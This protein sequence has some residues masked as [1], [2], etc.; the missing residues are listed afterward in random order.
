MS[1]RQRERV[2]SSQQEV[3]YGLLSR[4]EG[5][6]GDGVLGEKAT[7]KHS[8][9]DRSLNLTTILVSSAALRRLSCSSEH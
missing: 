1:E 8:S 9:V 4:R 7:Q 2:D 5:P 6:C 3:A